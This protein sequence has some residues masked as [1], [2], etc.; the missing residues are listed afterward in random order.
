MG[1]DGRSLHDRQRQYKRRLLTCRPWLFVAI[2]IA[3]MMGLFLIFAWLQQRNVRAL[4][5]W[6]S[7]YLIGAASMALW[8]APTPLYR[9]PS[10]VPAAMMFIACGMIW[11]A[12]V[13]FTAAA[14]SA[15]EL[16]RRAGLADCIVVPIFPGPGAYRAG[17]LG[18][19]RLS[20][21]R[22]ERRSAAGKAGSARPTAPWMRHR[23]DRPIPTRRARAHCAAANQAKIRKQAHHGGDANRHESQGRHVK[24]RRLYAAVDHAGSARPFPCSR[25][26]RGHTSFK[27]GK[28]CG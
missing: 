21:L 16:R 15:G 17:R 27:W 13:C 1:R 26:V 7:A 9:L 5:W 23:S 12:C 10:D 20:S 18:D 14:A 19:R 11:K 25:P 22:L 3:A 6:G 8:A 28:A 4:A 24:S 2:C